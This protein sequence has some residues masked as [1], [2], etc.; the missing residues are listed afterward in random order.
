MDSRV[1]TITKGVMHRT[2]LGRIVLG[3]SVAVIAKDV[4]QKSVDLIMTSPP[5][6]LVR[7]KGYGNADENEYVQWFRPFAQV[8]KR[9]LKDTGSLVIDI[10]GFLDARAAY[11]KSLPL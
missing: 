9:V 5:F 8:F 7:K 11:P 10:G 4:E 1:L 3:N 6:A 2:A